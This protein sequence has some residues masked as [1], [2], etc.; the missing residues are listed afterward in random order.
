MKNNEKNRPAGATAK[1]TK[2]GTAVGNLLSNNNYSTDKGKNQ[3]HFIE[4]LLPH[5]SENA[6]KTKD[7]LRITGFNT[8]RDLQKEIEA[9]RRA[10]SL[11]LSKTTDGGGYFLPVAGEQ[12]AVEVRTFVQTLRARA[13]NTFA[14]LKSANEYLKQQDGN[15]DG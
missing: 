9:E 3:Y 4:N 13:I 10:G 2:N 5:G 1:R 8:V 14:A 12:G 6:I 7:L 15:D 11:I